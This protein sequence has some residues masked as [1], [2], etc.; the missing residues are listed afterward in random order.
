MATELATQ[1][2]GLDFKWFLPRI[3]K[4]FMRVFYV[5]N[6]AEDMGGKMSFKYFDFLNL[7][8]KLFFFFLYIDGKS[9]S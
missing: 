1:A 2:W 4:T 5:L 9:Q 8:H 3:S 6:S 7:F